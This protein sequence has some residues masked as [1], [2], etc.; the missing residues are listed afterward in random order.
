M[1]DKDKNRD[2]NEID[3]LL[4]DYKKQ[5]EKREKNFG[6]I[7]FSAP[8]KKE[9]K[10]AHDT[11]AEKSAPE[12]DVQA[13]KSKEPAGVKSK[14]F[15][16]RLKKFAKT[17][18][19]K[20]IFISFAA[21]FCAVCVAACGFAIY[22]HQKNAYLREYEELYPNVSFPEGIREEFCEQYAVSPSTVGSLSIEACGYTSYVVQSS[23]AK[24]T[25]LSFKNTTDGLDFNTVIHLPAGE[26]DLEGAFSDAQRFL[27]GSQQVTYSTLY[28]DYSFTVIGAF[29]TNKNAEDDGGYVFPYDVTQ[30]MTPI[31]FNDYTDR[32]YHRFLYDSGYRIDYYEDKLLTI[33]ADSDLMPDFE[34]VVVCVQNAPQAQSAQENS[35]VHYPQVW[36]DEHGQTNPYRFSSKWYPTVYTDESEEETSISCRES[37]A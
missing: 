34:F 8:A 2:I 1:S 14:A 10:T 28:E 20:K 19:G 35:N 5:K 27:S 33:A 23:S 16:A 3:E 25:T 37:A 13:Q 29:Y 24:L 12:N 26:C 15:F 17:K 4:G 22:D 9:R 21:V 11:P 18:K 32:L 6:K 36:Y 30:K 31:S 7:D